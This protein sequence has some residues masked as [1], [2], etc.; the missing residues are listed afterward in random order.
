MYT[1]RGVEATPLVQ[2]RILLVASADHPLAARKRVPVSAL[3]GED[4]VGFESPSVCGNSGSTAKPLD[5]ISSLDATS[6]VK[7]L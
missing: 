4:L 5:L 6:R 7:T 2:D 1:R 3:D